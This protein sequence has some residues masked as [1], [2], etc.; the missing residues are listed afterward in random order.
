MFHMVAN[1]NAPAFVEAGHLLSPIEAQARGMLRSVEGGIGKARQA[2]TESTLPVS[3]TEGGAAL[4]APAVARASEYGTPGDILWQGALPGEVGAYEAQTALG[5]PSVI[6]ASGAGKNWSSISFADDPL[7]AYGDVGLMT[8]RSGMKGQP[9]SLVDPPLWGGKVREH[10]L[11]PTP[12]SEG[13][14]LKELKL[15]RAEGA[16]V[17]DPK[18]TPRALARE[19]KA[20]GAIPLNARFYRKLRGAQRAGTIEASPRFSDLSKGNVSYKKKTELA[21]GEDAARRLRA[22]ADEL[23]PRAAWMRR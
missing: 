8:S 3:L 11:L 22:A 12:R 16:M 18:T 10:Q 2:S 6:R 13:G 21:G 15:P 7:R 17:Y 20:K 23:A 14:L 4:P 19:L 9:I 5:V 1:A